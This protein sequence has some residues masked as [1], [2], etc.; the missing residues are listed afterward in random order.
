MANTQTDWPTFGMM[1][2]GDDVLFMKLTTQPSGRYAY[3]ES[4]RYTHCRR[5]YSLL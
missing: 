5:S 4:F 2:N 1:T 3:H